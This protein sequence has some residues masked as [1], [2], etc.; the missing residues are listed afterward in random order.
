[1]RG[2]IWSVRLISVFVWVEFGVFE[3]EVK[4]QQN[5]DRVVGNRR[6]LEN[7]KRLYTGRLVIAARVIAGF[8]DLNPISS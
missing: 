8:F 3:E 1:M 4:R 7:R 2:G 5:H 6:A